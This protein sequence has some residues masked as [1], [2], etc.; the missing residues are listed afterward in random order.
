VST[1]V[2]NLPFLKTGSPDGGDPP[3]APQEE[4]EEE[5]EDDVDEGV[6][7][8]LAMATSDTIP[9]WQRDR[10]AALNATAVEPLFDPDQFFTE[11]QQG[12]AGGK[13]VTP[14]G[15]PL[16]MRKPQPEEHFPGFSQMPMGT[17]PTPMGMM[18]PQMMECFAM[19]AQYFKMVRM[20]EA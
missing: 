16:P 4:E 18:P 17:M 12:R 2:Y 14:L 15:P 10:N 1:Y 11:L 3:Y 19:A 13:P 8:Q 6:A 5:E 9:P 20:F 7:Q